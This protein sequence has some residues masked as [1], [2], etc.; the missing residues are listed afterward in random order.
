MQIRNRSRKR[1][2]ILGAALLI[3]SLLAAA[4]S[5][6]PT[7]YRTE[8]FS[9]SSP[10]LPRE[11]TLEVRYPAFG[12]SGE[13]ASVDAYW[14]PAEPAADF[15]LPGEPDPVLVAEIQSAALDVAPAGQI[16]TPLQEGNTA[17]FSWEA[18]SPAAGEAQFNLFFFRAGAEQVAG[19]YLQQP[20][21]ARSF[22]YRTFAG[23]RGMKFPLLFF[24]V[25]GGLFGLAFLLRNTPLSPPAVRAPVQKNNGPI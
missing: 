24:A 4:Y 2:R 3:L 11:Y 15:A 9:V 23:P 20:V 7:L 6:W 19:V 12:P 22:P 10:L 18:R 13:N 17:H 16:S 8:V 21:W 1:N 14:N 5:L 25:F